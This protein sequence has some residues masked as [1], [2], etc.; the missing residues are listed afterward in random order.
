MSRK[1]TN[2]R[3]LSYVWYFKDWE[4]S[5]K[6][7]QLNMMQRGFY[8]ELIDMCMKDRNDEL[9]SCY[10]F[11][12][13][14]L[15]IR[16]QSVINLLR[17][18]QDLELIE[19]GTDTFIIP[20]VTKRLNII[21]GKDWKNETIKTAGGQDK[22]KDKPQKGSGDKPPHSAGE[23]KNEKIKKPTRKRSR[24]NDGKTEDL[25][26]MLDPN[27]T[28]E[29]YRKIE[30]RKNIF[31]KILLEKYPA[32]KITGKKFALKKWME[33]DDVQRKLAIDNVERYLNCTELKY[34]VSINK[35]L[36]DEVYTNE[37]LEDKEKSNASFSKNK[38]SPNDPK[39]TSPIGDFSEYKNK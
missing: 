33:M 37:W 36:E 39:R 20:S 27:N 38:T 23:K 11:Y 31:H 6:V 12:V 22:D 19:M 13:K 32:S 2:T 18:L 24:S 14:V 28:T 26:S 5:L 16:K 8:R 30:R 25:S 21:H 10:D 7:R 9:T 4:G 1:N 35:Y 3:G 34:V 17:T 29:A 15:P